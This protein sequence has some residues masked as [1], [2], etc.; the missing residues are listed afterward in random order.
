MMK[1]VTFR[2]LSA[3]EL[4]SVAVVCGFIGFVVVVNERS[5]KPPAPTPT[6]EAKATV[7]KVIRSA[8]YECDEV[9]VLSPYGFSEGYTI[10]CAHSPSHYWRWPATWALPIN[11]DRAC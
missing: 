2:T 3:G 9:T 8:G 6:A 7:A 1:R 5:P 4:L 10:W 11:R